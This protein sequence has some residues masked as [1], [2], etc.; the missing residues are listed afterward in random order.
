MM[1]GHKN[2][3]FLFD[4]QVT[5]KYA[6]VSTKTKEMSSHIESFIAGH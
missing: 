4:I 1:N 5:I 2:I 6:C 3:K